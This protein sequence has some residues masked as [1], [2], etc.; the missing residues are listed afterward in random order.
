MAFNDEFNGTSLDLTR[1]SNMDG[2][3][4]NGPTL[5]SGAVSVSGGFLNITISPTHPGGGSIVSSP[6][7]GAGVN[8][9]LFP[10]GGYV[11]A[12][13]SFPGLSSTRGYNWPAFWTSSAGSAWP[14]GGE[15]DI[16]EVASWD[17]GEMSMNY[18]GGTRAAPDNVSVGF[19]SGN[20]FNS[21]HT[22]A[23]YRGPSSVTY[24][25]DGVKVG[26]TPTDDNGLPEGIYVTNSTGQSAGNPIANSVMQVDYVRAWK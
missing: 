12:R 11:E 3:S 14:A 24:Y 10:V 20:W 25:F 15:I 18:H 5:S 8:G 16:A 7:L 23:A 9:Y 13:I 1:W 26:T 21:F 17:V 19:P 6:A 2:G 22:Y 4:V